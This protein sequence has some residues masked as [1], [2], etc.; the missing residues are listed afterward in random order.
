MSGLRVE[1]RWKWKVYQIRKKI[2]IERGVQQFGPLFTAVHCGF[3]NL[4]KYLTT[5]SVAGTESVF[6]YEM[7]IKSDY[8]KKEASRKNYILTCNF[9]TSWR[10]IRA[11]ELK[12]FK[13]KSSAKSFRKVFVRHFSNIGWDNLMKT[14]CMMS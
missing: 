1:Y 7:W 12:I 8:R 6:I 13:T 10:I 9:S 3:F 11:F 5:V 14:P 2:I 4:Q